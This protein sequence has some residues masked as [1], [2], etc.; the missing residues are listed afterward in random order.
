MV[1]FFFSVKICCHA[2]DNT[3]PSLSLS[4]QINAHSY[5]AT[6]K[7][8]CLHCRS[9]VNFSL[10]VQTQQLSDVLCEP[11]FVVS[12][13]FFDGRDFF[14]GG[15]SVDRSFKKRVWLSKYSFAMVQ[16]SGFRK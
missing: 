15:H 5:V 7:L 10:K 14:T 6:I 11:F 2:P 1:V 8:R 13:F 12:C 16:P 3:A 4:P 9:V